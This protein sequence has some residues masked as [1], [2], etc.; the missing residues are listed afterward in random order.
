M[1]YFFYTIKKYLAVVAVS[2]GYAEGGVPV[3]VRVARVKVG[4]RGRGPRVIAR[5]RVKRR[6][7][8]V[9]MVA[10]GLRARAHFFRYSFGHVF[11]NLNWNLIAHFF[12][13]GRTHLK[14]D[15]LAFF[16]RFFHFSL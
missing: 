3:G 2:R 8:T 10:R 6:V 5:G 16:S 7:V 1:W 15:F 11:Y 12:G 13:D 4:G 9:G 14:K